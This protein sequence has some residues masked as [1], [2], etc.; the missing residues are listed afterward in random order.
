MTQYLEA[1]KW[2]AFND[3][4]GDTSVASIRCYVTTALVADVFKKTTQQVAEAIA[5]Q[6]RRKT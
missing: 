3:E 1:V 4:D 2:I 6:R 5:R